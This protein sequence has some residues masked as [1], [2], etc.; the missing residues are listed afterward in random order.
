MTTVV[1]PFETNNTMRKGNTIMLDTRI[2]LSGSCITVMLLYL[3]RYV[4]LIYSGDIAHISAGQ[5]AS[6]AKPDGW[7]SRKRPP[8]IMPAS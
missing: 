5:P 7:R 1:S 2:I 6:G 3:M 8:A 4:L